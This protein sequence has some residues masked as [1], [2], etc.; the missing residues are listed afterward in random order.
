[1]FKEEDIIILLTL[2]NIFNTN[3]LY[4][5][6]NIL[7]IRH[8]IFCILLFAKLLRL[9]PINLSHSFYVCFVLFILSF[10]FLFFHFYSILFY[11]SFI[12]FI[13]LFIYFIFNLLILYFYLIILFIHIS[14]HNFCGLMAKVLSRIMNKK[15]F[16]VMSNSYIVYEFNII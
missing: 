1:M 16:L 9:F 12:L 4:Y 3:T 13:Y 6:I 11:F 5:L 15:F 10:Y 8:C 2:L 7:F 14:I